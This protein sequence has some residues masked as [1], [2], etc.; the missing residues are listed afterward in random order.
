[1]KFFCGPLYLKD[2]SGSDQLSS[3]LLKIVGKEYEP[4]EVSFGWLVENK[5]APSCHHTRRRVIGLL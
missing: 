5:N 4:V 3:E 2:D 1:M